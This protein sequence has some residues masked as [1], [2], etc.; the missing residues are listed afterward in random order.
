MFRVAVVLVALVSF[1]PVAAAS[2]PALV[3]IHPNPVADGDRG[4][5]VL[6]RVPNG[7][8][9]SRFALD[10][11]E[12]RADL[13]NRTVSGTV[14]LTGDP[15]RTRNLTD[16][17]VVR[18]RRFPRLANGGEHL[19]LRSANRTV[20][21]LSYEDAPE[22]ERRRDGEWRPL[23]GSAFPVV[24]AGPGRARLFVLP[25]APRAPTAPVRNASDRL[26]LAG[27]T[28]TSQRVTDSLVAAQRRGVDVHVLVDGAPVG[29]LP[30][31]EA[32]R[33][34]RLTAAGVDVRVVSGPYAP[35]AFHH[36]KY[37]VADERAVVVTEN[38]KPA[39]TGGGSSRGWG[40]TVSEP[41]AVAA[42]VDTF[43]S[44]F[45]DRGA[46]SWETFRRGETYEPSNATR[47]SYPRRTV[48]E[49]VSYRNVSVLVAPDNAE[50]AVVRRLDAA[51]ESIRV[52]QMSI[53]GRN[54]PFL[55]ACLRAA[56]RGVDVRVLLSD[57]WYVSDENRALVAHLDQLADSEGLTLDAKVAEPGSR[58]GKVHA[59]GV[60]VD[61]EVILGSM[62][63]N[64]QSARKNREVL[65]AFDG[66]RVASYFATAFDADWKAADR[67]LPVGLP[68]AL[69]VGAAA[70]LLAARRITFEN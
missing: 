52:I 32:E 16:H 60:V 31:A 37:A 59:K 1:G 22:G 41:E 39:G 46:V 68:V 3:G 20:A 12:Q 44:D 67:G 11:G 28:L 65:L 8:D 49:R 55:R 21:T 2:G 70:C 5:F 63:W 14:A 66:E 13:P 42:L 36:A 18:V 61:D 69:G 30:R 15:D 43:R 23:T 45:D 33:L 58:F 56:R 7:T 29:G 50:Q 35:Y 27:Y 40:A 19:E 47:E 26:L 25:D 51:D 17:A 10:D 57:A 54:Q 4:E 53:G 38:W 62:N 9:L 6:L 48:P 64:N 24:R 34:D